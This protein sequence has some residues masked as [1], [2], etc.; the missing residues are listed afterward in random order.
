MAKLVLKNTFVKIN[1]VDLS[2]WASSC[3]LSLEVDDQD[4]TTFG[5][6]GWSEFLGGLKS[7]SLSITFKQDFAAGAVDET[8]WP[9]FGTLV[10]FAV[11]A[12]SD[13]ASATN[14]EYRG[15]VLVNGHSPVAGDVGAIAESEV[16]WTTSGAITR[17]TA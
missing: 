3:E 8:L 5:S 11:R 9:L 15:T 7:G 13:P 12:T 16:E 1:G 10:P 6:G 14:P 4:A 2:D 17:A